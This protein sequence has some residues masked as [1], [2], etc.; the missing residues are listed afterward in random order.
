METASRTA[1]DL[2]MVNLVTTVNGSLSAADLVTAN[3][4]T[5]V[6]G[7]LSVAMVAT[8]LAE[9]ALTAALNSEGWAKNIISYK[10]EIIACK[11]EIG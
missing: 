9:S 3:L 1:A 4:I 10:L 8:R 6:N 5:A 11:V 2:A 7:S